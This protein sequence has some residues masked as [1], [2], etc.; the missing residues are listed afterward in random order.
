[1]VSLVIGTITWVFL[2]APMV[3]IPESYGIQ[4][5]VGMAY[6]FMDLIMLVVVVRLAFGPGRRAPSFYLMAGA[7]VA[8]FCTVFVYSSL[9]G[10]GLVYTLAMYSEACCALISTCLDSSR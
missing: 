1:M 5:L 10:Q 9:P 2:M 8:L 3:Q 7:A 4:R 6:P